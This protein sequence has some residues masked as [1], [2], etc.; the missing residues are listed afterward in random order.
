MIKIKQFLIIAVIYAIASSCA[1]INSG[2]T[3]LWRVD[4]E[5]THIYLLGSIHVGKSSMYPLD[6]RIMTAYDDS[7]SVAFEVDMTKIDPLEMQKYVVYSDGTRLSDKISAES[8]EKLASIFDKYGVPEMGYRHMKPFVAAVTAQ[9]LILNSEGGY[10]GGQGIDE[11]FMSQAGKDSKEIRSL[12]TIE[13]QMNLFEEFD[14]ISDSYIQFTIDNSESTVGEVDKM[15]KAWKEGNK[16]KLMEFINDSKSD[17]PEFED[18]FKEL[19]DVRNDNMTEKIE[20]WLTEERTIFV[21]V[22]A[23]H[24]IGENGIISQLDKTGKYTIENY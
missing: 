22:G 23:G 9:R 19:I 2:D 8:Y 3:F 11:Y 21:V 18:I 7:R 1:S 4:S 17:Y 6:Y 12:E 16:E 20:Q 15:I 14:E 10:T 24:L 13:Y 5:N